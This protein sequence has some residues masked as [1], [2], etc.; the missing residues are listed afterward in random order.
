VLFLSKHVIICVF[1]EGIQPMWEDPVNKGGGRWVLNLDKR[2]RLHDLNH[3]WLETV[4]HS[5]IASYC[6]FRFKCI[7]HYL[8]RDNFKWFKMWGLVML[9]MQ[10]VYI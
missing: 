6:F 9:N 5:T 7:L 2:Q 4:S 3:L 8:Y 1:Q 10:Y